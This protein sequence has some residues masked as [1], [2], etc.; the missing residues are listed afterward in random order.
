MAVV[1]W[2]E[3]HNYF[4]SLVGKST[5]DLAVEKYARS[6]DARD[7]QNVQQL[8]ATRPAKSPCQITPFDIVV[9]RVAATG[10][11]RDLRMLRALVK[12]KAPGF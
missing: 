9:N 6:G 4:N 5:F 12:A 10:N 3:Q 7:L 8:L 1:F 11:T 2:K